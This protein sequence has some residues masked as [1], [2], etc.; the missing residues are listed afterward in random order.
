MCSPCALW[1]QHS[2]DDFESYT[3][4]ARH[5]GS[6]P[7]LFLMMR[8]CTGF[9]MIAQLF[10][11]SRACFVNSI[12]GYCVVFWTGASYC[13][14]EWISQDKTYSCLCCCG[15]LTDAPYRLFCIVSSSGLLKGLF[16]YALRV[17]GLH[18]RAH[19]ERLMSDSGCFLI[20]I[21]V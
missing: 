9:E 14:D 5:N 3:V 21:I 15:D 18:C 16:A 8:S 7:E 19:S 12:K 13:L 1:K 11:L 20:V 4:W 6:M 2:S 10:S 17:I